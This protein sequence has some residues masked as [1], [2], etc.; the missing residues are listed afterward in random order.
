MNQPW[1][2]CNSFCR[3]LH[4]DHL[5][6]NTQSHKYL[7]CDPI[8]HTHDHSSAGLMFAVLVYGN[9]HD[10]TDYDNNMEPL[11]LDPTGPF[12]W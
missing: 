7:L 9:I 1:C 12:N 2:G 11:L 4:W 6:V 3:I 5:L 10:I 8:L